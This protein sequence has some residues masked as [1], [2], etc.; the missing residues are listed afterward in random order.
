[1]YSLQKKYNSVDYSFT[2]TLQP[3]LFVKT[4]EDQYDITFVEVC[5]KL[6]S[7]ISTHTI[8]AEITPTNYNIHYHGI[9]KFH[10]PSKSHM[11]DFKDVFR[12]SKMFG[13][14]QIRQIEDFGGWVE[15]IMKDLY[16][17]KDILNRPPIIVD[18]YDILNTMKVDGMI[19][20]DIID[21]Q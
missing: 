8:I 4:I 20:Y 7:L 12:G 1:M 3:R 21:E 19:Q 11:K 10:R 13:F 2:I 17:T 14:T 6:N 18:E 9:I 16:I 15:Y 5:R